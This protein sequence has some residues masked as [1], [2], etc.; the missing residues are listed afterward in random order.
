VSIP[1]SGFVGV[2]LADLEN[3]NFGFNDALGSTTMYV[4]EIAFADQPLA[5]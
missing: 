2:D 4:D 3:M 1:L 5:P